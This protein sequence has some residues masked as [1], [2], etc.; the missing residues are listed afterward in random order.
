MTITVFKH[1]VKSQTLSISLC[2]KTL[3]FLLNFTEH[4][5]ALID[6]IYQLTLH[7]K[8]CL[9]SWSQQWK[10]QAHL[11]LNNQ[12]HKMCQCVH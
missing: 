5:H 1:E 9:K 7:L 11:G 10:K 6:W 12:G 2:Q 8:C 4:T 3:T